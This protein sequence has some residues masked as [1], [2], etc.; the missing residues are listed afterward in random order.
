MDK[1]IIVLAGKNFPLGAGM[2]FNGQNGLSFYGGA[3]HRPT[4]DFSTPLRF[5]QNDKKV[6]RVRNGFQLSAVRSQLK[7]GGNG[8]KRTGTDF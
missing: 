3:S 7:T 8:E 2:G 6:R 1:D 5:A 4:K